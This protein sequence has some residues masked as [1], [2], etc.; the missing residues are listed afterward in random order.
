MKRNNLTIEQIKNAFDMLDVCELV[1]VFNAYQKKTSENPFLIRENTPEELNNFF[2]SETPADIVARVTSGFYKQD[3]DYFTL[4]NDG[5]LITWSDD[6]IRGTVFDY[7]GIS[8]YILNTGDTFN[9]DYLSEVVNVDIRE[10]V[11]KVLRELDDNGDILDVYNG[12]VDASGNGET[13]YYMSDFNSKMSDYYSYEEVADMASIGSFSSYN[14]YFIVDGGS[15]ESFDH[16]D[17]YID[18]EELA[19]YITEYQE[20][21]GVSELEKLFN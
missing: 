14:D 2:L 10:E 18:I 7:A 20:C 6:D 4:R 1:D 3:G 16:L 19:D 15:L 12:Y 13:I 21:F 11:E 8:K 9:N 5:T 17:D